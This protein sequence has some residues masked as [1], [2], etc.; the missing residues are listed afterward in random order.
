LPL[1]IVWV[2][3]NSSAVDVSDA[4][5]TP[6]NVGPWGFGRACECPCHRPMQ[7]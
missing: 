7:K 3:S 5:I 1:Q 2:N 6:T 4:I